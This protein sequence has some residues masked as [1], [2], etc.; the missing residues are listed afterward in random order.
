MKQSIACIQFDIAFGNPEEN[1]KRAAAAIREAVKVNPPDILV[2]PE[3]WNTG[4]DL[5]R[6]DEI[7][8]P[9]GRDSKAFLSALAREHHVHLVAG[10]IA[11]K[12]GKEIT[13]T[14]LIFSRSGELVHEYSKIHL[15][16]LMDEHHYLTG[17][18]SS[19]LFSLDGIQCAGFICYDIRFP[20]WMR[21]HAAHGAE[22]LFVAAEW[23]LL[24]L[25]H[26]RALLI[27]RAIENQAFVV[28]CNRCGSDPK[29]KFAGHSIIID[30]WGSVLAEAGQ[31]AETLRAEL[32]FAEIAEI[33]RQIP[34]FQDRRPELYQSFF[35]S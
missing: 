3:L 35:K 22:V 32:D 11:K 33:R 26:W 19:G 12:S 5:T 24:R 23:P 7:A 29:N 1:K 10:S 16:K 31:G 34:V 20:E 30:P 8:D 4:Y 6:L 2:L 18:K 15:F 14:M 28:A 9:E 21:D 13:N 17:G 25:N 27:A